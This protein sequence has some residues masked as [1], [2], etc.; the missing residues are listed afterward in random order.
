MPTKVRLILEVLQYIRNGKKSWTHKQL[1]MHW[2]IISAVDTDALVLKHQS[3]S[4]H[5]AD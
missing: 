1:E 4:I 3:I 5:S 2:Y